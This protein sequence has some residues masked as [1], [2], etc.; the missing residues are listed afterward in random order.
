M[1]NGIVKPNLSNITSPRKSSSASF[2][3]KLTG[4]L[5]TARERM[6]QQRLEKQQEQT[7]K[8]EAMKLFASYES[9]GGFTHLDDKVNYAESL[10]L[11]EVV[12]VLRNNYDIENSKREKQ[13]LQDIQTAT[14][15]REVASGYLRIKDN[16]DS[17]YFNSVESLAGNSM[18]KFQNLDFINALNVT[19]VTKEAEKKRVQGLSDKTATQIESFDNAI[20]SGQDPTI[21]EEE[22]KQ[23]QSDLDRFSARLLLLES[24]INN[25]DIQIKNPIFAAVNILNQERGQRR[26]ES[27]RQ[28]GTSKGDFF[29]GTDDGPVVESDDDLIQE[30][31]D[32]EIGQDDVFEIDSDKTK[33][34]PPL[35]DRTDEGNIQLTLP[36][37]SD[38]GEGISDLYSGAVKPLYESQIKQKEELINSQFTTDVTKEKLREEIENIKKLLEQ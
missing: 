9:E 14:D 15:W 31:V 18:K 27:L 20:L 32:L 5:P 28:I 19:K 26:V 23:L 3:E 11:N 8:L 6:E 30:I 2:L 24:E 10:G 21:G 37:I 34:V 36:T 16:K 17:F 29:M 38:I 22:K 12:D 1:A 7:D 33:E 25:L 4:I 13:I 35:V